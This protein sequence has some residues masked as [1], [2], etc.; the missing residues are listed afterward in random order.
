MKKKILSIMSL[1][2]ELQEKNVHVFIDYQAHC[3]YFYVAIFPLGW[4]K[5]LKPTIQRRFDL[6]KKDGAML[7]LNVIEE[8]LQQ[9]L[10]KV[11]A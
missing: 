1:A 8:Y 6:S 11:S 7:E 3:N 9:F 10:Q 2:I 4:E 5:D